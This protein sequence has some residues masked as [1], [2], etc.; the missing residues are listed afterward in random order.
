MQTSTI[1]SLYIID[2]I[3]IENYFER[4]I[5]HQDMIFFRQPLYRCRTR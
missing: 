2:A 5:F 4:E 3:K 1:T